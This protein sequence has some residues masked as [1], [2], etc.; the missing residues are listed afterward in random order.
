[1]SFMSALSRG[2][3]RKSIGTAESGF[4]SRWN[5]SLDSWSGKRINGDTA[6]QNDTVWACVRLIA[7]AVSTLPLFLYRRTRDG[8]RELASNHPLYSLL[9]SEPNSLMTA[10]SFWQAMVGSMLLW[11]NAYAEINRLGGRIVSI[12]FLNPGAVRIERDLAT[13]RVKYS[14][15]TNGVTREIV[16]KNLFH[17]KAFTLDG[18]MGVSAIQ[19]GY[20]HIGA[21][22]AADQ[23]AAETFRDASRAS[24]I[25]T[26]DAVLKPEQRTQI[27]EH[28]KQVSAD[29]GVYV[30]EKGAGFESLR[31]SPQDAELLASRSFS[32]ETI[33]RWFR[34][35]PVMIGHGDKQS[36][37]PTSTEAQGALFLRYVLRSILAGIEQEIRRSLLTPAEKATYFSEYSIEGL[38]RGDSAARAAFYSTALQ[39]GWMS[40]NEVRGL[41]NLPPVDGGDMLTVQSN[42][43]A[44]D[45]MGAVTDS[46]QARTALLNWLQEKQH[47]NQA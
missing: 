15:T 14:Y 4:L 30:L 44:I 40:R 5:W 45:A 20:N 2:L 39:N 13:G 47:A 23:A 37:W 6:L 7:D 22:L 10:V 27:R 17:A 29:G 26:V 18:E 42:M 34:V 35:P 19:Y 38:L 31:F 21:S 33:C 24:G 28:V 16:R 3:E 32:V 12:D 25:V 41:E 8:G 11:G 46:T 36:S 1:M 9:H 43:V